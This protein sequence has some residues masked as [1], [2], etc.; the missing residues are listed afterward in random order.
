MAVNRTSKPRGKIIDIPTAPIIG[1]AT[2]GAASAEVA[3]TAPTVGGP[4][5]SY[6]ALSNP[7]SVTATGT[8]S[9][10]TV[11]GLT[12]GTS[13]TFTVRGTNPSG[14]SEYSTAS[15]SVVPTVATAFESIATVTVGTDNPTTITFSS[16]PSTYTHLQIRGIGRCGRT[17]GDNNYIL[18]FNSD[19]A[20]NYAFHRLNG[21]GS[22]VSATG[23]AT[24]DR[25][26]V[27][28]ALSSPWIGTSNFAPLVLDIL[29]YTN[30]NK[31]KTVRYL[32]GFDSNGGNRDRIA[33][34]SGLWRSTSAI[35]SITLQADASQTLSQYT[36]LALY[37]IKSS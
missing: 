2:A 5:F 8:S 24:Q 31:F 11:T 36:T 28:F 12:A 26:N 37:G 22:T 21:T 19:S 10:I 16:I 9:P 25:I 14:N 15:N 3:F 32:V 35:T 29:D 7:G 33:L 6:T 1:A 27:D 18:R 17:D 23:S 30:T 4:T 13:Y 20:S 34:G